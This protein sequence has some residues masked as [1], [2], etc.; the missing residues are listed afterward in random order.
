MDRRTIYT[1]NVI[2]ETLIDLLSEKEAN[3]IT[4]SEI[5][6]IA[7]INR[8]T[9]YRYY[10]DVFDLLDK[11]REE[12]VTEIMDAVKDDSID[13]VYVFTK[14]IFEV[15]SNNKKLVKVLFNNRNFNYFISEILDLAYEKC[16]RRWIHEFKNVSEEN[17]AYGASFIFNGTLGIV[18]YWIKTDFEDTP[19][20]VA[21]KVEQLSYYGIKEYI[22][23]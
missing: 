16:H 13:T 22:S 17:I 14:E 6:K 15:L 20:E 21:T 1:K 3:K 7:D 9:F 10:M 18:Y 11:I 5:C 4:V 12:F 19:E 8:A 23:K 2:K